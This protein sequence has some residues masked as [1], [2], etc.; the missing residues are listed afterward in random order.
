MGANTLVTVAITG[1]A[2]T[3]ILLAGTTI[4]NGAGQVDIGDFLI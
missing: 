2:V 1:I 3:S 4:G